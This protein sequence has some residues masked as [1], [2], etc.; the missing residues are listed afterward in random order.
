MPLPTFPRTRAAMGLPPSPAA[1]AP[2]MHVRRGSNPF[3]TPVEPSPQSMHRQP[4]M[5][6]RMNSASKAAMR[7]W[8]TA[9]R[10]SLRRWWNF[11]AG[12][13]ENGEDVMRDLSTELR[14]G[15]L[16][17]RMAALL[18]GSEIKQEVVTCD[19]N[20][21][22]KV[23]VERQRAALQMLAGAGSVVLNNL[24]KGKPL[25]LDTAT[26]KQMRL[27]AEDLAKG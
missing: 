7:S 21:D 15:V 25:A 3:A 12:T 4:T 6:G 23:T 26:P 19:A 11:R 1:P 16:L 22:P 27:L 20:E 17:Y 5:L 10:E 8:D 18:T 2:A 13:A 14:S 9:E 24:D